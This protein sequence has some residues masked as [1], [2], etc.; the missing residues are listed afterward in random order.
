MIITWLGGLLRRRFGRLL[1]VSAGIALA[2]ALIAT[3]GAFLTASQ[4]TMTAR[5][6]RSV[7]V[8]W[9]VEVQ[10]GANPAEVLR[11]VTAAPDVTAA[12]QVQFASVKDF[13][14]TIGGTTQTAG[15]GVVLGL[16]FDYRGTFPQQIRTLT[17]ADTGALLG[18]RTAANL[19][20][21][22]GDTIRIERDGRPAVIATWPV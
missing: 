9:Q 20:S 11:Q 4:S 12:R 7:A 5:A 2:V 3:L 18:R 22:P 6:L 19:R 8:D 10:P 1:A 15:A 13:Q 21:R 16:P 17:G 14:A